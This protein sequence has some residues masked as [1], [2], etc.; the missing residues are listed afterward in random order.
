VGELDNILRQLNKDFGKNT[1]ISGDEIVS[2]DIERIPTGSL[3]LDIETGGGFP[4]GRVVELF[5]RESAGKTFIALKAVAEA[6]KLGKVAVWI[7]VEGSFDPVWSALLGVDLKKLKLC[8]P[9]TG[10][11]ACDIMDAVL[12][13]GECGILVLDSTAALVPLQDIDTAMNHVEQM[14]VRAK[15]VNRLIRKLHSALNMKV[16]EDCLQ[17]SCLVVFINQIR[18]KI[19]VAFGNPETT[20]GGLGLRHAASIRIDIHKT[21]IKASAAED[22]K[23]IIGQT[24]KFVTVKNKT[25]PPYRR[26]E[27]D[28]YVDGPA[29]GQI[30]D[31]REVFSYGVITG[32][33]EQNKT[34]YTVGKEEVVGKEKTVAYLRENPIAVAD[35]K[36]KI[37]AKFLLKAKNG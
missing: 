30:D 26:G 15:M 5:G 33:I 22:E 16:G 6:Q 24:I 32:L 23:R 31:I 8:R 13:S 35:L 28:I 10:E 21:W 34:T 25:F 11:L 2:L 27:F 19:G 29:K 14:G 20:P 7:D 37:M 36:K 1:I 18:E 3:S 17:N 9:E 4:C 12:R